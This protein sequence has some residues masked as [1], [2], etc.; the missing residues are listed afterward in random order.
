[1]QEAYQIRKALARRGGLPQI[2]IMAKDGKKRPIFKDYDYR[3]PASSIAQSPAEP[4]D[5]SRLLVYDRKEGTVRF[6]RFANIAKY[7]PEG[8]VL[9]INET[10]VVPA[11]FFV[12][13]KTGGTVELFYLRRSGRD[14]VCLSRPPIRVGAVF[15]SGRHKFAVRGENN[16]RY[17]IRPSFPATEIFAFLE[18][19]G[20]TPLPPYLKRS[21]L[22]EKERRAKYQAVFASA[23]GSVAAPTASLHFTPRLIRVLGKAGIETVPLTLHVNLG[24]FAPLTAENLRR[25]KLH[26]EEYAISAEAARK[27]NAAKKAGRPI[28]AL[29]TTAC[30][31]L[32]SAARAGRVKKLSG[33][34]DIFIRPPYRFKFVDGLITNFHVPQSS[35]MMLV[36]AFVG[37]KE[38][39]RLY[40]LSLKNKMRFLSFGDG[41]LIR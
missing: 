7:L 23:R 25:G 14:I 40:S 13:K 4:R 31:A 32:E 1:M 38:L 12:K 8:A 26:E 2:T 20:T 22:S 37:R 9:A 36:A 17:M 28:V 6:D 34:T 35:L 5:G 16:G 41:M 24:T 11:R 29:G 39:L 33:M 10:K 30:R 18:K 19:R 27:L 21:P 15:Y 3:L